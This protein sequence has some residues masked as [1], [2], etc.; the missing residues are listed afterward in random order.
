LVSH[1]GKIATSA[2]IVFQTPLVLGAEEVQVFGKVL[3]DILLLLPSDKK[4]LKDFSMVRVGR[5]VQLPATGLI[6]G[7]VRIHVRIAA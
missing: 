4:I 1:I 6:F 2:V 3:H 5:V 7:F